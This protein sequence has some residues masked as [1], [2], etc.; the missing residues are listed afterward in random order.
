MA[1]KEKF[2]TTGMSYYDDEGHKWQ[3]LPE[4]LLNAQ[5]GMPTVEQSSYEIKDQTPAV[6]VNS[7]DKFPKKFPAYQ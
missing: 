2:R 4:E 5:L 1:E 6:H 3:K 7:I